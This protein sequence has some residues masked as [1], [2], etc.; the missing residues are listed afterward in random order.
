[1]NKIK[2]YSQSPDNRAQIKAFIIGLAVLV[3][4][5]GA[6]YLTGLITSLK[7]ASQEVQPPFLFIEIED[8]LLKAKSPA[9]IETWQYIGP[10]QQSSCNESLFNN[11]LGFGKT[12]KEGNQVRLEY[13]RDI[14][15]YYCFKG[16]DTEGVANF[17]GH[18][19]Q[20]LERPAIIF[21]Q[22]AQSLTASL[23]NHVEQNIFDETSWQ[24]VVLTNSNTACG[25]EVF[26]N[27]QQIFDQSRVELIE[28]NQEINYCFRIRQGSEYTYQAKSIL[29][30][31]GKPTKISTI[32]SN[33]K[34]YL[35]A[36]QRITDWAVIAAKEDVKCDKS[37]FT[38]DTH[39]INASQIAIINFQQPADYC[40]RAQNEIGIFSYQSYTHTS[41]PINIIIKPALDSNANSLSLQA[42]TD[43]QVSQ[44][45]VADIGQINTCNADV[46][47][48]DSQ[49]VA[50]T[51]KVDLNYPNSQAHI[52]CWQ[53][54]FNETFAYAFYV[55][56]SSN[57]MIVAYPGQHTIEA[58]ALLRPLQDW[59][60]VE[61][62]KDNNSL[63][64]HCSKIH[65][66]DS[67]NSGQQAPF[68]AASDYCFSAVDELGQKHYG[69]WT[70]AEVQRLD[71]TLEELAVNLAN[72]L[73]LAGL[74][75]SILYDLRPRLYE[76]KEALLSFCPS[77][78]KVGCY[79]LKDKR[80]H[81]LKKAS[82]A[83]AERNELRQGIAQAIRHN[84]LSNQ[85]RSFLDFELLVLYQQHRENFSS[86]LPA[87][88][89]GQHFYEDQFIED[90]YNYLIVNP[91]YWS[92]GHPIWRNY[93]EL[94]FQ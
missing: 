30:S 53:A 11:F 10:N 85:Q 51:S 88:F 20:D 54:R 29:S 5:F 55:I 15:K 63:G 26:G 42:E 4:T 56:P 36:D 17:A 6:T 43:T 73:K 75:R 87:N 24:Y 60:Y 22:T 8:D 77:T 27:S 80:L 32:K 1:M 86:F 92:K 72:D 66:I 57:K 90:F 89:Y 49:V 2:D 12:F 3:A 84:Y 35:L 9:T 78:T 18:Y 52:Y 50:Q 70:R 91:S 62:A 33:N 23:G 25:S 34:L 16:V 47:S 93:Y 41:D 31:Q 13:E 46:F 19:I 94:F 58:L 69:I 44:W 65:F 81:L 67:V 21:Q 45:R 48:D 64:D 83:N 59:Q 37:Y 7:S 61:R 71:L 28:N 82:F 14:N 74:G 38:G 79:A 40:I 76:N 68:K 39:H